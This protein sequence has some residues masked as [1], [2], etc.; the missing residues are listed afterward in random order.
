[1]RLTDYRALA[2]RTLV[3]GLATLLV[4]APLPAQSPGSAAAEPLYK[5]DLVRLLALARGPQEPL[6]D[7]VREH[8]VAFTPTAKDRADLEALGA[9]AAFMAAI[10]ACVPRRPRRAA[11]TSLVAVRT[12]SPVP[13]AV[14]VREPITPVALSAPEV[15]G[16]VIPVPAG[17]AL[18]SSVSVDRPPRLVNAAEVAR[19]LQENYPAAL[20]KEG[21]GGTVVLRVL[22]DVRGDVEKVEVEQ[23]GPD[24]RLDEAALRLAESLRF[25]PA[26]ARAT[27]ISAWTRQPLT[28][29]AP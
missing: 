15:N 17:T 8:C 13:P 14:R 23:P 21:I 9:S 3:S 7:V 10:D 28:F 4:A 12:N 24:R 27:P 11:E 22:V 16:D 20:R 6:A 2:T 25:E 5:S 18:S 29:R 26:R 19:L 1:M